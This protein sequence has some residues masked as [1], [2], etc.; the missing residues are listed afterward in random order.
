M[1]CYQTAQTNIQY[2]IGKKSSGDNSLA[3]HGQDQSEEYLLLAELHNN[4]AGAAT[5]NNDADTARLHFENYKNLLQDRDK[6]NRNVSDTRLASAFFNVGLSYTMKGDY[7][8]ALPYYQDALK[9]AETLPH[10]KCKIART[11]ALVNLGLTRWLMEE[12]DESSD[13][14]ET[15]LRERELLLG[16]N[17][18]ESMM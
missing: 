16:V 17:D 12:Y 13:L 15:A 5:E 11:L 6:I 2:I 1:E 14:L 7:S 3:P 9:E 8:S 18:R 4:I 10:P